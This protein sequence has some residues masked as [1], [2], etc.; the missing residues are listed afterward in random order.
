MNYP[1]IS[2]S[3]SYPNCRNSQSC[4]SR[5]HTSGQYWSWANSGHKSQQVGLPCSW[6]TNQQEVRFSTNPTPR[7]IHLLCTST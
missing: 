1:H 2:E 7:H 5:P 6:I 4:W 3:L